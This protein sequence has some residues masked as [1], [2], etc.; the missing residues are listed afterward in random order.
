MHGAGP[1]P[2]ASLL[3]PQLAATKDMAKA[4]GVSNE[5]FYSNP[6]LDKIIRAG[7]EE[8]DDAKRERLLFQ[9][10]ETI[11]DETAVISLH[12]EASVWA[13]RKDLAFEG[14]SDGR[15]HAMEIQPRR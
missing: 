8:V 6:E 2:S 10:A 14:R 4:M 7:M 11:R 5:S 1:P 12:Y 3:V 9:A 15:S 13:S